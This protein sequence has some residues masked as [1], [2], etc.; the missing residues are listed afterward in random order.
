MLL[1]GDELSRTQHGNNNAYCQ[2]N[3]LSWYDWDL[4]EEQQRFLSYTK[5]L[6]AFR[7]SHPTFQRRHFLKGQ[8]EGEYKDVSWWHPSGREMKEGDWHDAVLSSFAM[9]LCGSAFQEIDARGNLKQDDTFL[10][11]FHGKEPTMFKLPAP[12][13]AEAWQLVWS[14]DLKPQ[15]TPIV[16]GGRVL[17]LESDLVSVYKGI[18]IN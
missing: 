16:F 2:D 13:D 7:K 18:S 11:L 3:P 6:I 10:V 14:S 9:L 15:A 1:G 17:K 12:N 5:D 4:N 8:L